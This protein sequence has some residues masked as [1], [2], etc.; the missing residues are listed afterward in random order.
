MAKSPPPHTHTHPHTIVSSID[1]EYWTVIDQSWSPGSIGPLSVCPQKL[2]EDCRHETSIFFKDLNIKWQSSAGTPQCTHSSSFGKSIGLSFNSH[3]R[4]EPRLHRLTF[5]V[6]K[7]VT[8]RLQI[9]APSTP[10]AHTQTL[11]IRVLGCHSL[12]IGV[13]LGSRGS[14]S[15]C[16]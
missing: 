3:N 13:S 16:P 1:K 11:L 12:V 4:Y 14:L 7:K 5:F 15:V 2:L 6:P 10:P 8:G 9:V